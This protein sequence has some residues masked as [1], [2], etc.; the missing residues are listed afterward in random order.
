MCTWGRE[1]QEPA[2]GGQGVRQTCK[3]KGGGEGKV[4]LHLEA[5]EVCRRGDV[6]QRTGR[7]EVGAQG[8]HRTVVGRRRAT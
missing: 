1:R 4:A 3:E 2:A 6:G 5:E 7:V 8:H